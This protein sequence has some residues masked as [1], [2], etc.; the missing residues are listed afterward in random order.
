MEL[1]VQSW[2]DGERRALL[3]H[4]LSSNAAGWW[5]VAPDLAAL[6]YRVSAPDLRGHG[7]SPPGR[8]YRLASYAADVLELGE[9]WDLVLGHSLGGAVALVAQDERPDFARRLILEDPWLFISEGDAEWLLAQYEGP[10]TPEAIL[11]ANP[12]WHPRDAGEK[13]EALRACDR[14]VV[15]RTV[16]DNA[17]GEVHSLAEG[18]EVPTLLLGGDPEVM[19]LVPPA[20]GEP[21]AAANPRL[22]F[23]SVSGAGHSIHRDSYEAF[24]KEMEAFLTL[25]GG[26]G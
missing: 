10:L 26:S 16:A 11:A 24:R 18:V 23:R 4:G 5:R 1:A 15:E 3:L 19:T 17:P 7:H 6:G 14:E 22:V 21:L 2:G 12:G 9:G 8:D 13:A 20:L 25:P